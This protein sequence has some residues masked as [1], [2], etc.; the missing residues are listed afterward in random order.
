MT[1]FSEICQSRFRSGR[2]N[3]NAWSLVKLSTVVL[4]VIWMSGCIMKNEGCL[5]FYAENFD[6]NAE[7]ACDACCRYPSVELVL[8]QKWGDENFSVQDTFFDLN[9][10]P[11]RIRDIHYFLTHWEW[12]DVMG[13]SNSV[14]SVKAPC[15]GQ[16]V[17]YTPDLLVIHWQNFRYEVGNTKTVQH[18][19]SLHLIAGLQ[20]SY[21]C[22]DSDEQ[23]VP[24]VLK[25][26]NPLW[27]ADQQSFAM[28]RLVLQRDPATDQLDTLYLHDE[29]K[30]SLPFELDM[31]AGIDTRFQLTVNYQLWF[32]EV[33]RGDLSSFY[34]SIRQHIP[35]SFQQ[36]P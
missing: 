25:P 6:L 18:I 31:K 1:S 23:G 8:S 22:H 28:L 20:T 3:A 26:S 17:S 36:T 7:A 35:S 21:S 12:K 30:I 32:A 4:V 13:E 33:L 24:E 27:D 5:D 14:E 34:S 16:S 9:N 15:E 19:D 11:Y 2:W 10:E 29:T